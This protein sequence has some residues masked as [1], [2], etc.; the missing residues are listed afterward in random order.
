MKSLVV[1]YS[2]EGNTKYIAEKIATVTNSDILELKPIKDLKST[3]FMKYLWGG[4][5]VVTGIKPELMEITQDFTQYD[6]I[7]MGTPVWAFSFT[8]AF[9][10]FLSNY[11]FNDKNIALF[12]CH[13]GNKGKTFINMR[14]LLKD[15]NII[16]EIDF[17]EP[18]KENIEKGKAAEEWALKMI[19]L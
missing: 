9:N 4:R 7:F 12:C 16:G 2:F 8:P 17:K 13:G 6:T 3:G 1:F 11:K 19:E 14:E 10:T 15:N 18:I 5:Q